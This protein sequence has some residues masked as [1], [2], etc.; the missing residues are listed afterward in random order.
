M[1]RQSRQRPQLHL[2]CPAA[3]TIARMPTRIAAGSFGHASINLESS[4]SG[5]ALPDLLPADVRVYC[6]CEGFA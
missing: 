1:G 3:L 5:S 4:E 2:E 6:F